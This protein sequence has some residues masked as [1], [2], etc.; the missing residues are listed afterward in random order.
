MP[1][2]CMNSLQIT[3]SVEQIKEIE[4]KLE[5]SGGKEFFDIFVKN[6]KD[7]G[8]EEDWYSYK[9]RKRICSS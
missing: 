1:N 6:A 3:G 4:S 5:E 9:S 7:A 2:W 8:R